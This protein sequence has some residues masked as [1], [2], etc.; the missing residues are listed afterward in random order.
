MP[1][2]LTSEQLFNIFLACFT[3]RQTELTA[4]VLTAD[5]GINPQAKSLLDNFR[6]QYPN[7]DIMQ[8]ATAINTI[9]AFMDTIAHNN[10]AISKVTPHLDAQ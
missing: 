7:T 9:M 1:I 4:T 3:K 5:V 6:K 2:G 8:L 10:E